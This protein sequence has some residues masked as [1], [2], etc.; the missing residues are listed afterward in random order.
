[1]NRRIFPSMRM[2]NTEEEEDG[3]MIAP[4]IVNPPGGRKATK[5]VKLIITE[6]LVNTSTQHSKIQST[7]SHPQH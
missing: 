5:I 6:K 2:D 3:S 1:M 4:P 7:R